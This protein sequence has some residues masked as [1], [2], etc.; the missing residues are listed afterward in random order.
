MRRKSYG[1]RIPFLKAI[2]KA[3]PGPGV[4]LLDVEEEELRPGHVKV[5]VHYGSIC[6]TDL[7]I[8]EW[9]D[10]AAGRIKPPRIIGHEFRGVIE[11][12]ADDVITLKPGDEIASESHIV[13]GACTQCLEGNA[14]VCVNT[15]I[16]GVDI[17]G[18]FR[19]YA[20]IPAQATVPTQGKIPLDIACVQD[21]LG[22]AV[23]TALAGPVD[24]R[25]VLIT[26]MGPI[27][28]F[29]VGVC[30]AAGARSVAVTEVSPYRMELA[31]RMGA[32]LIVNPQ[33]EDAGTAFLRRYPSGFDAALEMSGHTSALDLAI[34]ATRPGGRISLLGV[35]PEHKVSVRL[36]D[37]IFKGIQIQCIV[38]RRLWETWD[39]MRELLAGGKL[40]ISPVITHRFSYMDFNEAIEKIRAGETG[41][42]VFSF[43]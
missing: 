10:W 30:K 35:F 24:G 40:D 11:S 38:G 13:C 43:A 36:N 25:D 22:N 39:Q 20:V 8:V 12:V 28:L 6:G 18:G 9:D 16:L 19:A 2:V 31:E 27:G 15:E 14:H 34:E 29:A 37:A 5:R 3:R 42:V 41:K 21:P 33:T 4:E 23:H 1:G 7:H 17:D 32:D 26:G